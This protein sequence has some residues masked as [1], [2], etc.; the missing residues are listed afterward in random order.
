MEEFEVA[1]KNH[2]WFYNYSDDH[3]AW[4]K[5]NRES[6]EISRMMRELLANGQGEEA[7]ETY[8]RLSPNC[9]THRFT[10]G[11]KITVVSVVE[12]AYSFDFLTE[13]EYRAQ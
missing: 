6:R 7:A 8:N 11:E 2:D 10:H 5:G 3:R 12:G 9:N 4:E 13:D 1:L